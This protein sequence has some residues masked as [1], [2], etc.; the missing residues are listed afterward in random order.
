M[1]VLYTG[2]TVRVSHCS[3]TVHIDLATKALLDATN[4]RSQCFA[5]KKKISP[6]LLV[7]MSLNKRILLYDARVRLSVGMVEWIS[8]KA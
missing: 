2:T 5:G 8:V 4:R 1:I 3:R 7:R 6:K